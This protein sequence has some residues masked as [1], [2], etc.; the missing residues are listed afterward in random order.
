MGTEADRASQ[1]CVR[2]QTLLSRAKETH[3]RVLQRRGSEAGRIRA[4]THRSEVRNQ[5]GGYAHARLASNLLRPEPLRRRTCDSGAEGSGS[6]RELMEEAH[7]Y[8]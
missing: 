6:M 2:L 3:A 8:V 4:G 7:L 5:V 1:V